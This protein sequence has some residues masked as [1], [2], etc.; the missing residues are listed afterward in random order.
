MI[1]GVLAPRPRNFSLIG[2][3]F[4][5]K[6]HILTHLASP[7]GPL[8]GNKAGE[9]DH[10]DLLVVYY[11]CA[12]PQAQTDLLA[13]LADG[14]RRH[15][16]Q[17]SSTVG[18]DL[19]AIQQEP[20]ASE[21]LQRLVSELRGTNNRLVLLLDNFDT[22]INEAGAAIEHEI[23]QLRPLTH[24]LVL[25]V[26]SKRPLHEA[27][28]RL[29][30]SP[31]F[32]LLNQLFLRLIEPAETARVLRSL[33][34]GCTE[35]A[36]LI[37]QLAEWTGG[38][39]F[40]LSRMEEILGDVRELLSG[41]QAIGPAHLPLIRL[42]LTE[43]YGRLLF[44]ELWAALQDAADPRTAEVLDIVRHLLVD[45]LPVAQIQPASAPAFYWLLNKGIVRIEDNHCRLFS[46]LFG[47]YVAAHLHP[48]RRGISGKAI[49]ARE[50][51]E[52]QVQQFTPQER[53]LMRYFLDRPGELVT[54]DQ[55]LADVWKRP[56]ASAR[57]VQEGIRRLRNRLDELQLS[58]GQIENEWGEGYRFVPVRSEL[59]R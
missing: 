28:R 59:L 42:R 58:I 25:I 47:E 32:S 37:A 56:H 44:S 51:I 54:I 36:Q 40:L 19:G 52:E 23:N 7:T 12:W 34:A 9:R 29:A 30:S 43:D 45:P 26:A 50:R 16:R 10:E 24:E 15:V 49:G 3:K 39:P 41:N 53:N 6:T 13:F 31:L 48:S 27:N 38:H 4:M 35:Q 46:P 22:L 18:I 55:L 11:D 1:E 14:L 57:R 5:G 8:L 17:H 20:D 21:R 33:T 2:A